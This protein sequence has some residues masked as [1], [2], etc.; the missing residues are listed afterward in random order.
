LS[1][2]LDDENDFKK[3]V[4]S[5]LIKVNLQEKLSGKAHTNNEEAGVK[6]MDTEWM[7][8]S[9]SEVHGADPVDPSDSDSLTG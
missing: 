5:T 4:Q 2:N 6:W 9:H 3:L 8:F 7:N 1:E